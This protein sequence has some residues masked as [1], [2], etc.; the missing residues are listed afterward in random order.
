MNNEIILFDNQNIKLEVNMKDETVW[1]TQ[2][3]MSRLFNRDVAVISRHIRNIFKDELDEKS[4]L[5]KMQIP[6]SDKPVNFYNLDV[7]ISVGYRVK[8]NNGIIFRKWATSV[9][10]DHLLKGITINQRRL[11]YLEKKVKLIDIA[12]RIDY[13]LEDNEYKDI[14]KVINNYNDALT[15]LIAQSDPKE[16]DILVDVIMNFLINKKE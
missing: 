7:I 9:L 16:K 2:E 10:K 1:L 12:N 4:N 6:N 3:Q 15:L 13:K 14:L 8:S 11:D 5:Q